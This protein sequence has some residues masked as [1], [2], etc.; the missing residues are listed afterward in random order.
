MISDIS[1]SMSRHSMI[2]YLTMPESV[3]SCHE[4]A[5]IFLIAKKRNT[6][7]NNYASIATAV[8]YFKCVKQ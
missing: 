7:L 6:G 2:R 4:Y 5:F 3:G 1:D 8:G